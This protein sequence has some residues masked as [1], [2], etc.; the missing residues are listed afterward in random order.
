MVMDNLMKALGAEVIDWPLKT[1]CCG[2][3]LTGTVQEVGVRLSYIIVKE[4]QKR[5]AML[6]RPLARF[7]SSTSNVIKTK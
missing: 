6:S 1:R 2:G 3:S 4:A 5:G 7:A